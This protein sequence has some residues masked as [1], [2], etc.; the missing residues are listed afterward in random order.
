LFNFTFTSKFFAALGTCDSL[1]ISLKDTDSPLDELGPPPLDFPQEIRINVMNRIVN[2][3]TIFKT[4][5]FASL[6]L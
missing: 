2:V 6:M 5:M 1:V 3:F 4:S